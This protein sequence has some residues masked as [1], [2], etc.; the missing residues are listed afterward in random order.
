MQFIA[1]GMEVIISFDNICYFVL[2]S[3]YSLVVDSSWGVLSLV[4]KPFFLLLEKSKD[5]CCFFILCELF[6][7]SCDLLFPA[8]DKWLKL[9]LSFVGLDD[10]FVLIEHCTLYCEEVL[11]IFRGEGIK[12]VGFILDLSMFLFLCLLDLELLLYIHFLWLWFGTFFFFVIFLRLLFLFF[13]FF[14]W[15]FCLFEPLLN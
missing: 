5:I 7:T 2:D 12:I 13:I 15:D 14:L 9:V 10:E 3:C 1:S 6:V 8:V 11:D 4:V